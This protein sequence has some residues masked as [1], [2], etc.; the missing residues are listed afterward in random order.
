MTPRKLVN[1]KSAVQP[2]AVFV[3]FFKHGYPGIS[4]QSRRQ[5]EEAWVSL[6]VCVRRPFRDTRPVKVPGQAEW[7]EYRARFWNNEHTGDW[8]S[9]VRVTVNA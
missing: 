3:N 2:D 7:R 4:T 8:S 5:G 6:G 9:V 1:L